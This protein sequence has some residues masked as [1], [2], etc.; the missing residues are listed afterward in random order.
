MNLL[1]KIAEQL[2]GSRTAEITDPDGIYFYVKCQQCGAPV[3]VRVDRQ[4]D[5][6]RDDDGGGFLLRKE[7]MD[8]R[9]F[10][11]MYAAVRFDPAYRIVEQTVE[12]GE[13][14]TWEEYQQH[15]AAA[16]G[17]VSAPGLKE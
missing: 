8:G 10:R 1:K 13:F 12:G 4:H 7:I 5:L 6:Q 3:R 16:R 15:T 11:L 2:F 9:C 17:Q 14:I